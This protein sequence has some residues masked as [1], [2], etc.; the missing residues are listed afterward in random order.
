[1]STGGEAL[2]CPHFDESIWIALKN[3]A[4]RSEKSI[5]GH[6][7]FTKDQ[8]EFWNLDVEKWTYGVIAINLRKKFL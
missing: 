7:G 2:K 1:M 3:A 5:N 8:Y 4:S 6:V